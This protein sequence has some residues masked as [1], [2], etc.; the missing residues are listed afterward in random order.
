[1]V[2]NMIDALGVSGFSEIRN[3]WKN[4][5]KVDRY[6]QNLR[7]TR[8]FCLEKLLFVPTLMD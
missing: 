1:M 3:E 6:E 2:N 7:S 4:E 5:T 8:L